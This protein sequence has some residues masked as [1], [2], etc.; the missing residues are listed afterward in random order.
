MLREDLK[1][2]RQAENDKEQKQW[3]ALVKAKFD[4]LYLLCEM[5]REKQEEYARILQRTEEL[6]RQSSSS[7][8]D[9][10]RK[11]WF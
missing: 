5:H 1:K 3:S 10:L 11:H 2:L 6:T 8:L 4:L 7:F 9:K